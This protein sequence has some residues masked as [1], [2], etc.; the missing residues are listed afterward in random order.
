MPLLPR[1]ATLQLGPSHPQKPQEKFRKTHL[2]NMCFVSKVLRKSREHM[3][4]WIWAILFSK[5]IGSEQEQ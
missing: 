3:Y 4:L 1:A 5:K 2:L